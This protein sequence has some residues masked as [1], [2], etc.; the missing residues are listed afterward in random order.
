M[1]KA[2]L[3]VS[4]LI[5]FVLVAFPIVFAAE[6]IYRVEREWVKIWIN[7]DGSIDLFYNITIT[8]ESGDNINYVLVGQPNRYFRIVEA[9]DQYGN[10]LRT[11]DA[12]SGSDYKVRVNLA[13]PLKAGE[14]IWF[15]IITNVG[16]MIYED[17]VNP[18]NVGMSF[19]PCW[20]PVEINDLRILIVLPLGVNA[21][22]VKT[23]PRFYYNGTTIKEDGRLGI[24]WE[25]QNL[26][27]NE[28]Y[29]VGVSFPK[30]YVENYEP[31]PSYQPPVVTPSPSP[32]PSPLPVV[33]PF[34]FFTAFIFVLGFVAFAVSKKRYVAPVLCMETLG[35]R[36][37][38]TAVEASYLLGLDPARIVAMIL[39]SLLKK[40]AVWVEAVKPAIKLRRLPLLQNH[41]QQEELLR[42]YE[43]GFLKAIRPDGTLDELELANVVMNLRDAVE[44][45]MRGYC[46]RDT[47]SYYRGVVNKAWSQVE[48]AGTPEMAS[49]LFDR[50][51][52][53]LLLDPNVESRTQK[54]F[55]EWNFEP[56]P[57]WFWYWY[58]Y[59]HYHPRPTYKPEVEVATQPVK[60]SATPTITPEGK[61]PAIPG[62]EF[63]N[64]I[65]SALENTANNIV[66]NIERFVNAILPMPKAE[67]SSRPA[68]HEASCVCACAACACACACV[69]C[70]CACASGGV[71]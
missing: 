24:Y 58:V 19:I 10:S 25:K 37:G 31:L 53:W 59:E 17:A 2:R 60:P 41:S 67:T 50:Q 66:I 16:Q 18:G 22:M 63:A 69:S 35:I 15:A 46:R 55:R 34:L 42:Y 65:A 20:W 12:S 52:L 1:V 70:A 32:S 68:H 47:V 49:K 7:R 28:Q 45:K 44:D 4:M 38:L 57:R 6:R 39:Y 30:E 14:K 33:A 26:S 27:G 61:P 8:L 9:F 51:L 48:Q 43:K 5:I 40:R 13:S 71:G 62:A 29:P 3:L 64:N 54:V 11:S 56:S 23:S 21:S 36:R